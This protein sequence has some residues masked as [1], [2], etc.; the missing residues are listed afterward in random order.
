MD[1]TI[2]PCQDFYR[3][4]CGGW[5]KENPLPEDKS[6]VGTFNSLDETNQFVLKSIVEG[7]Y[8]TD[9]TL[10]PE[11]KRLD[12]HVFDK[13][14]RYYTACLNDTHLNNQG[15]APLVTLLKEFLAESRSSQP[16]WMAR[17]LAKSHLIE[18]KPVFSVVVTAD[19]KNPTINV[20]ELHQ[21]GLNLPSKEYYSD[22]KVM[23]VY[24]QVI[25]DVQTRLWPL[26]FE[27][28][29]TPKEI[30]AIGARV[31]SLEKQL[32]SFSKSR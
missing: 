25:K 22:Q 10:S 30:E 11:E 12:E 31:L 15:D 32:A 8:P 16:A 27:R 2:K 29:F 20:I 23:Q 6:T 1:T 18:L 7:P 24:E 5:L 3:F 28:S 9:P 4:S 17:M 26:V 14:Q 21:K 13:I 19:A